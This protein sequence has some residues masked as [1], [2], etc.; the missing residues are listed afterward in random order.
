MANKDAG[1]K[2]MAQAESLGEVAPEQ[3]GSRKKHKSINAC[4]NKILLLDIS[5]YR[6]KTVA[7]AMNDARGCYDR[8]VHVV[9]ML[10]M[11]S[12]GLSYKSAKVLFET[13]Q[14]ADHQIKTGFGVSEVM[15]GDDSTP[16]M[17]L[18]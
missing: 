14:K 4:L 11:M 6:R 10:V 8:I 17:G 1:R 2:L 7:L 16:H 3:C 15:Y 5:R 9:A 12:F 13:L 18:G